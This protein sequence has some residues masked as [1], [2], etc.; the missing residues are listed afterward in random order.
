MAYLHH[1]VWFFAH[2][3]QP[4]SM[5]P[6]FNKPKWVIPG[7]D[8]LARCIGNDSPHLCLSCGMDFNVDSQEPIAKCPGRMDNII[9]DIF[10]LDGRNCPYC[11]QG[12]FYRDPECRYIS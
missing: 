12:V 9:V 10:E 2:F 1:P 5:L 7:Q 4:G 6:F 11:K 3:S 8:D